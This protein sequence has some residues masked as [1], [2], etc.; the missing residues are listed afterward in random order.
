MAKSPQLSKRTVAGFLSGFSMRG[1]KS[2]F[3][4]YFLGGGEAPLFFSICASF[5]QFF[6]IFS[7][8]ST[9]ATSISAYLDKYKR[10]LASTCFFISILR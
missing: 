3:L 4:K 5:T 1:G 6:F 2:A 8:H 10:D 7:M 9:T